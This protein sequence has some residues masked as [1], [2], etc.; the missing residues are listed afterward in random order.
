MGGHVALKRQMSLAAL[1]D[2]RTELP[3]RRSPDEEALDARE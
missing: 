3:H 2:E 1:F